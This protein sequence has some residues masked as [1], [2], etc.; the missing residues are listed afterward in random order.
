MGILVSSWL[1]FTLSFHIL[2][3]NAY[4]FLKLVLIYSILLGLVVLQTLSA[5]ATL[6]IF[7]LLVW[8]HLSLPYLYLGVHACVWACVC[9]MCIYM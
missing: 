2:A 1:L 3:L 4:L 9:V 8:F 7:N 5:V 6:L